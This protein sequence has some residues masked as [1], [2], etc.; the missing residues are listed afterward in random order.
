M[1]SLESKANQVKNAFS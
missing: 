1:D